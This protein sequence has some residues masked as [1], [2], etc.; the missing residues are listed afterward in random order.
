MINIF[1]NTLKLI[2]RNEKVFFYKLLQK[3]TIITAQ[4]E[5]NIK[6]KLKLFPLE[7]ESLIRYINLEKEKKTFLLDGGGGGGAGPRSKRDI[8]AG[9]GPGGGA[10]GGGTGVG[11]A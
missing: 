3:N 4:T 1:K 7:I 10:E 11:G 6:L 9:G 8:F 5:Q 2:L